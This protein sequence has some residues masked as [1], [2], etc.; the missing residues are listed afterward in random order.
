M[1]M[2]RLK[3]GYTLIEVMLFLAI[4]SIIFVMS[5]IVVQGQE[6]NTEFRTSVDGVNQKIQQWIDQVAN[7]LTGST[8]DF[9]NKSLSCSAAAVNGSTYPV[10]SNA[11]A[12]N[13]ERG[14]NPDCIFMGK[15]IV[16]TSDPTSSNQ[17][18]AIPVVG[19]RLDPST[20]DLTSSILNANPIAALSIPNSKVDQS[21]D[22]SETYNIPSGTRVVW[23]RSDQSADCTNPMPSQLC[24]NMIGLFTSLNSSGSSSLLTVNYQFNNNISSLNN[25]SDR[26]QVADCI[27]LQ[28]A[29]AFPGGI[30]TFS[31]WQLCL[32][33]S[34]DTTNWALITIY[35]TSG[36]SAST[37]IQYGKG[38]TACS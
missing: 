24:N 10:L 3:G 25:S 37:G 15:V 4:S 26:Q 22:L 36:N 18:Y 5:L 38:S 35:S 29:C 7:G 19:L 21:V 2:Q 14:A 30:P 20:N 31:V 12:T 34:R 8:S 16:V 33:N 11:P 27:S 23:A 6:A 1:L 28:G 17:I 9:A 32:Q 13:Q